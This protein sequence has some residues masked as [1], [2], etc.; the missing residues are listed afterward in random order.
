MEPIRSWTTCNAKIDY[1]EID[2]SLPV[3][4]VTDLT[5]TL[6]GTITPEDAAQMFEIIDELDLGC[7]PIAEGWAALAGWEPAK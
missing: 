5:S 6:L 1:G 3:F 7:C 4:R 2:N